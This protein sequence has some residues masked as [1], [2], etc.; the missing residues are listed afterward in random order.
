MKATET[1][2]PRPV[3]TIDS[4][5]VFFYNLGHA[6]ETQK[7]VLVNDIFVSIM[8]LGFGWSN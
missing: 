4:K 2:S 5:T 3:T 1:S 7:I 6:L 8:E